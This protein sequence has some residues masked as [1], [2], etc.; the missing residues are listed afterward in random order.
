MFEWKCVCVKGS[1]YVCA[2]YPRLFFN[3]KYRELYYCIAMYE[4]RR[5]SLKSWRSSHELIVVNKRHKKYRRTKLP[6]L[7][8]LLACAVDVRDE[9]IPK[10]FD[11]RDKSSGICT[12][13]VTAYCPKMCA[14]RRTGGFRKHPTTAPQA[15]IFCSL[16]EIFVKD[17]DK[18][19]GERYANRR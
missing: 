6:N 14:A 12:N 15:P 11:E 16:I 19:W 10:K 7:C 4:Q 5:W 18:V 3:R 8:T 13:R 1:V 9:W 17:E 2:I